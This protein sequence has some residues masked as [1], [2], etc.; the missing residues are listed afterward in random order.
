[1]VTCKKSLMHLTALFSMAVLMTIPAMSQTLELSRYDIDFGVTDTGQTSINETIYVKNTGSNDLVIDSLSSPSVPFSLFSPP[2]G[3]ST[4]NSGDSLALEVKAS[5][6]MNPGLY[7]SSFNVYTNDRDTIVNTMLQLSWGASSFGFDDIEYW[8]GTG[9][10]KAMLVI[11]F[12]DGTSPESYAW[13]YRFDSTAT[14]EDM[15]TD[16]AAADTALDVAM[17]GGML[18]DIYYKNHSGEA[19]NPDY[20]STWSGTGMHDWYT[21]MGISMELSDSS[22]F[23]CSYTDFM[24]AVI[25][26]LPVAAPNPSV[27]IRKNSNIQAGVFPNPFNHQVNIQIPKEFEQGHLKIFSMDGQLVINRPIKGSETLNLSDLKPGVYILSVSN[28][29]EQF[30]QKIKK[31]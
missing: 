17:A 31:R 26:T 27:G 22:W 12:N 3:G 5:L 21:N 23:G 2:S 9:S 25:P 10:H 14:A 11:S 1:M 6:A 29:Q 16:I 13:G 19:G 4:V 15:L 30:I 28:H 24:P 20:W 18:S 7:Q 8:V